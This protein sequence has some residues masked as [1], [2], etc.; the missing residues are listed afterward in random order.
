MNQMISRRTLFAVTGASLL[1][2]PALLHA[3][4]ARAS[5]IPGWT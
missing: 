4:A 2:V 3:Q 5:P 1:A